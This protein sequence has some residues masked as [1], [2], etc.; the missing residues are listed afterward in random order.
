MLNLYVIR[1]GKGTSVDSTR[2]ETVQLIE[3]GKIKYTGKRLRQSRGD[4]TT[5]RFYLRIN[6][7]PKPRVSCTKPCCNY[8]K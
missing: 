3:E 5:T 6:G 4:M 7:T 2:Q 1:D 8:A